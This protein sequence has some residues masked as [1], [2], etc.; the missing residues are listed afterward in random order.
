MTVEDPKLLPLRPRLLYLAASAYADAMPRASRRAWGVL[1]DR[2][3]EFETQ[4]LG[5]DPAYDVQGHVRALGEMVS[6][7]RSE[8]ECSTS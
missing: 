1:R 6:S 8:R 3:H 5:K 2:E 4:R 7:K